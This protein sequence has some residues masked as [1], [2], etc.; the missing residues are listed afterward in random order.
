MAD[1]WEVYIIRTKS[2][3]L[4]TGITTDMERRFQ[5]HAG[6]RQGARFFN[7]SAPGKIVF[8]EKHQNRSTAT[9]RETEIKKMTRHEKLKLIRE[10]RELDL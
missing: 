3:T 4:Y 2:G 5:E 10:S 6:K 7:L 8:R 9:R 1:N